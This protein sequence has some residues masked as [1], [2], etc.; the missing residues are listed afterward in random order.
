MFKINKICESAFVSFLL[1]KPKWLWV[2][3]A[4]MSLGTLLLKLLKDWT[5]VWCQQA[6]SHPSVPTPCIPSDSQLGGLET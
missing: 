6:D 4:S 3:L 5:I 1:P 2:P